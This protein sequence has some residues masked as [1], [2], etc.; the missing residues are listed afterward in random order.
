MLKNVEVF[1]ANVRAGVLSPVRAHAR[2]RSEALKK[3]RKAKLG[4]GA[5]LSKSKEK[6]R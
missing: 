2:A 4:E 6:S 1:D 3:Q 5:R